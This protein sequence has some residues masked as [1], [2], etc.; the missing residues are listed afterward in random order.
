MS[1]SMPPPLPRDRRFLVSV[2]RKP[3]TAPD[4]TPESVH[5]MVWE[6]DPRDPGRIA[7][8]H[9]FAGLAALPRILHDLLQRNGNDHGGPSDAGRGAV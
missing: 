8:P 7:A 2:W 9:L 4:Q 6:A 1:D 3:A 5:G